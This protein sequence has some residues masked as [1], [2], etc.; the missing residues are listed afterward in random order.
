MNIAL[1]YD[2]T[3]TRDP[4]G[5]VKA[6]RELK[7]RGHNIFGV[8]MRYHSE[9]NSMDKAYLDLVDKLYFTSRRKKREYLDALGGIQI[10]VWI[11]DT[12]EFI[13]Y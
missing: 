1:D 9:G 7:K 6:I 2:E 13:V 12:P 5:W 4:E 3:F 10:H 8:T 11:D